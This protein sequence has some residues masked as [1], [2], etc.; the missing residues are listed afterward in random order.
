MLT[1]SGKSI[2]IAEDESII[3]LDIKSILS[4]AGHNVVSVV[5][6]AETLIDEISKKKSDLIVMDINLK[7]K[8]NGIQATYEIRK[9]L[10]VPVLFISGSNKKSIRD[11]TGLAPYDIIAKPYEESALVNSVQNLLNNESDSS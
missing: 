1:T 4:M 11:M 9:K 10:N 6:D 2:M 3:A 7:G 8:I 5:N